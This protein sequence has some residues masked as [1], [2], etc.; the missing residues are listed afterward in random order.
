MIF[1]WQAIMLFHIFQ[2]S[3]THCSAGLKNN[4]WTSDMPIKNIENYTVDMNEGYHP[5]GT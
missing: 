3:R 2:S 1:D 5:D 4:F